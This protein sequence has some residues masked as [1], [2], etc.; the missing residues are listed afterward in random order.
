M[1]T[2]VQHPTFCVSWS[3]KDKRYIGLCVE[4]PELQ[5]MDEIPEV[6]LAGIRC[7]VA[8]QKNQDAVAKLYQMQTVLDDELFEFKPVHGFAQLMASLNEQKSKS[9]R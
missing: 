4:Y 8:E 2:Y 1:N 3:N 9:A 5:W 7:L 6:A